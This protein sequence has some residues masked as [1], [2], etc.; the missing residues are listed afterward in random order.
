ML[1]PFRGMTIIEKV[2][3]NVT[4]SLADNTMVV[5]G[6]GKDEIM[7]VTGKLP[8]LHC[9]NK[10]YREGMLSSVKCGLYSLPERF[11]AVVIFPGDQPMIGPDIINTIIN[12]YRESGKGI[13]V[14]VFNKKRGHPL[15]V[16]FRYRKEIDNLDRNE[17]LRALASR[18][19]G[20]LL[21]VEAGTSDILRDID[22][23]EDY[24]KELEQKN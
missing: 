15:L 3:E 16:D 5:L 21:E 17:G 4:S 23:P 14:P 12:A 22:T 18:F 20:D 8:V 24:E 1:L 7:Q 10:D 2:I 13:V 9:H 6:A 19:P 11:E